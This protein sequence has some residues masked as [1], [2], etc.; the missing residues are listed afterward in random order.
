MFLLNGK[1][2]PLGVEFQIGQ[3]NYGAEWLQ[4]STPE[5]RAE[6]GIIEVE[7]QP[8]PDDQYYWVQD[9]NDGT[10]TATPKDLDSLKMMVSNKINSQAFSLLATSDYMEALNLRDAT[11]KPEWIVWR[12]QVRAQ[13]H[14]AKVNIALCED[15]DSLITAG[16]V[17]WE[18]DPSYA[19]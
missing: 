11:Y 15:I 13:A 4:K 5:E 9:N 14:T 6:I 2:L 7:E 19:E 18:K 16:Q 17:N 3:S 12:G 10:Y 8:R 1:K